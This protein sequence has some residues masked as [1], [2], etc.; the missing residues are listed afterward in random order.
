MHQAFNS[1][2]T[3]FQIE[4]Q[5]ANNTRE[6]ERSIE[7]LNKSSFPVAV[8]LG[9]PIQNSQKEI[10]PEKYLWSHTYIYPM[11]TLTGRREAFFISTDRAVLTEI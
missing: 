2:E 7:T 11:C 3:Y 9:D 6:Q 8:K 10:C 4:T 5:T 1:F